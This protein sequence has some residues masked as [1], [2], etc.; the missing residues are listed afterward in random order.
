MAREARGS[1]SLSVALRSGA[2]SCVSDIVPGAM[3][4]FSAWV[5][6]ACC[7]PVSRGSVGMIA[8][9]QTH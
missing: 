1:S 2:G 6:T 3:F 5:S 7:S 9:K 4:Q 8:A